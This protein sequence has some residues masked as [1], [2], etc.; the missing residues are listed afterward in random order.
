MPTTPT[1][2]AIPNVFGMI[3][4]DT[5]QGAATPGTF[6]LA[7]TKPVEWDDKPTWLEDTSLRNVMTDGPFYTGQG[8]T[9]GEVT[10]PSSPIYVDSFG[11]PLGNIMGDVVT[12][13]SVAPYA[14]AFSLLNSTTGQGT[15][16]TFEQWYGPTTTSG[17]RL[18]TGLTFTEVVISWD[19]M[20][21]WL[22]WSGKAACWMSQS[23]SAK[24]TDNQTS[25]L[26]IPA[27]RNVM[28]LG[29]PASG[30]TQVMT[31]K[32]GKIT[33]T[34]KVKPN[35]TGFSS[36]NPYIMQR[37]SLNAKFDEMVFVAGDES[38]YNYMI[39]NT[40]PQFQLVF[41]N[42]LSGASQG[43]LQID[44][45]AASFRKSPPKFADQDE[46]ITWNTSGK[47]DANTTNAGASGGESP[48]KITLTNAIASGVY[49]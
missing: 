23:A 36:Q 30:G 8:V 18:F 32:S 21:G 47:F 2:F 27:W 29:G 26:P 39:N 15:T 13:G 37:G 24:P 5:Y 46:L 43:G 9:L 10:F 25:V 35:W 28:G 4:K 16:H 48:L 38:I 20:K 31:C 11:F 40:I 44:A 14:S 45:Q 6:A 3:A 17:A 42:G 12:T 49:V 7:T 22:S 19:V 41:S 33:L 34:R 1:T